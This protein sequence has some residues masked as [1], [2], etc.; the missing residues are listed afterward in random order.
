MFLLSSFIEAAPEM[1]LHSLRLVVQAVFGFYEGKC[2]H[3]QPFTIQPSVSK[4]PLCG[5]FGTSKTHLDL[6][7]N[8]HLNLY[9]HVIYL[10]AH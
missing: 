2:L 5:F 7:C 3:F 8:V 1:P 10:Y 9:L 6:L 4:D